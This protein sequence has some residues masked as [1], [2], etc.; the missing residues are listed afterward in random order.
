MLNVADCTFP[1]SRETV[2]SIIV[3]G[4]KYFASPPCFEVASVSVVT[5]VRVRTEDGSYRPTSPQAKNLWV[6]SKAMAEAS[7]T[8]NLETR[9]WVLEAET[10]LRF[11][12]STEHTLTVVV[13]SVLLQAPLEHT[14]FGAQDS[15]YCFEAGLTIRI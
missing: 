2:V 7:H 3:P 11:D 15:R 5:G 13:S 8:G 9:T 6:K 1:E 4:I 12:V 14:R 10:E